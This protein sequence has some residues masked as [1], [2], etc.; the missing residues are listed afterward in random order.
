MMSGTQDRNT[1]PEIVVRKALHAEG[2]RF[3]VDCKDLLG[4]PDIVLQK[5]RPSSWYMDASGMCTEDANLRAFIRL[6]QS[7]GQP[8]FM[9]M[10]SGMR[11][12]TPDFLHSNSTF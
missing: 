5:P 9:Q 6:R 11:L 3:R 8:N 12:F 2:Y 10:R 7:S 1:K 4:K